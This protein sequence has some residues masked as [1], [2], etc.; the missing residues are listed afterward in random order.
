M[1]EREH[2]GGIR[3]AFE[4]FIMTTLVHIT[5]KSWR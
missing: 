3:L 4:P 1:G 5:R 2:F